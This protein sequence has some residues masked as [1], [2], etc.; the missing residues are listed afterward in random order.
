M[1][2]YLVAFIDA[3]NCDIWHCIVDEYTFEGALVLAMGRLENRYSEAARDVS[4]VEI[5]EC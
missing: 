3:G 5:R 1:K 2:K 4:R